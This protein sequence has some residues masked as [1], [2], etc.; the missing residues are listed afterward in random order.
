MSGQPLRLARRATALLLSASFLVACQGGAASPPPFLTGDKPPPLAVTS[1]DTTSPTALSPIHVTTK[2]L[3]S[4]GPVT[5]TFTAPSG[6]T[7]TLS[8]VGTA[9]NGTVTVPVPYPFDPK[10]G[11]FG[12]THLT[13][14][15]QQGRNTANSVGLDVQDLPQLADF[16]TRLGVITRTYMV[17]EEISLGRQLGEMIAMS[18][19]PINHV[20]L[21]R[22][23]AD[24]NTALLAV[25]RARNDVDRVMTNNALRI[26]AGTINGTPVAFDKNVLELTDRMIGTYLLS[27]GSVYRPPG[28]ASGSGLVRRPSSGGSGAPR[29][30]RVDQNG[31][32][33]VLNF[34]KGYNA[35]IGVPTAFR[36]AG[37]AKG[38]IQEAA[39]YVSAV[40]GTAGAIALV[41]LGPE[42]ALVAGLG[43][44][45]A[46]AT[47][48]LLGIDVG[49]M[50]TD[51]G[52]IMSPPPGTTLAG[53]LTALKN[54]SL[55]A[56]ND[57]VS[58]VLNQEKLFLNGISTGAQVAWQFGGLVSTAAQQ[59]FGDEPLNLQTSRAAADQMTSIPPDM[60]SL[61]FADVTGQFN[62][63]NSQGPILSALEATFIG[64]PAISYG[65]VDG[66]GAYDMLVPTG[67]SFDIMQ[68][69]Y[70]YDPIAGTQLN[71]VPVDLTGAKPGATI[72][73]PPMS[74]TCNDADAATPDDDDP[75]CD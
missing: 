67:S 75:D 4:S 12:A 11:S 26:P 56:V 3:D 28:S 65:L 43:L 58:V 2:G 5:A 14:T 15:L 45:A 49:H 34:L 54:D 24:V 57:S 7:V 27:M 69:L 73:A 21:S 48:V 36:S 23:K 38:P 74:A 44:I 31:L 40:A 25:I 16:G 63:G 39:G 13:M 37:N 17:Y 59:F 30:P 42:A 33:S 68:A 55:A 61:G 18:A 71:N 72:T 35:G 6:F 47:S 70:G 64:V 1:V 41:V 22:E 20:D 9:S 32:T 19:S 8:A 60:P 53:N 46:T 66:N 51:I 10:T 50:A 52:G 29:S 62:V